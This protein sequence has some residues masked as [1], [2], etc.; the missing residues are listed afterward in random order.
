MDARCAS[1]RPS[2]SMTV[3]DPCV[4]FA[5]RARSMEG[6]SELEGGHV[7]IK[8]RAALM[9]TEGGRA[10][11]LARHEPERAFSGTKI[12]HHIVCCRCPCHD[13]LLRY[14]E[15]HRSR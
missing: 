13:I 9:I 14:R 11:L 4:A 1:P 3:G 5:G 12:I 10:F 6:K 15:H 7:R 2:A 8:R